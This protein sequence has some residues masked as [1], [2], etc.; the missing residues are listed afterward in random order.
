MI[1][2]LSGTVF[3]KNKDSL[4]VETSGGVGYEVM[5]TLLRLSQYHVGQSV[6]LYT[7]L[8]VSENALD[9]Y[10]FENKNEKDFFE[11][12]MTVSGVG[13]KSAMNILSLG[14]VDEI[15][16]AIARGDVKY[17]TAVQGMGKKTAERLVVELKNKILKSGVSGG[18]GE[19]NSL[20]TSSV[21]SDVVEGLLALGY[22]RDEAKHMVETIDTTGKTPEQIL[23]LA[24][25]K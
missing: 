23:K 9:L 8:K 6:Q 2:L 11:L 18:E 4:V 22:S 13:P 21:V 7:Y 20:E 14:G 25:K 24:L 15:Q 5:M 1:S 3:E 19:V 17:L 10:G 12:L 16:S